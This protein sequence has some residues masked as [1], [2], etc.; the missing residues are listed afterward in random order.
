MGHGYPAAWV[1]DAI[2]VVAAC[3]ACNGYFNRDPVIGEV[4][5]TLDAFCDLR[6]KVFLER[7]A[8]IGERR[9]SERAWFE[10]KIKPKELR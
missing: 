7:K 8:R 9:A 1:L 6:D 4:P 2:N 10:A 3:G 5:T